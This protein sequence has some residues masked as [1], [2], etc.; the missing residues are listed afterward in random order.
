MRGRIPEAP[1]IKI[2]IT[3]IGWNDYWNA[4][5]KAFV[6]GDRAVRLHEQ[7]GEVSGINQFISIGCWTLNR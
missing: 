5:N 6:L 3:Q 1:D 7:I 4:L 2:S